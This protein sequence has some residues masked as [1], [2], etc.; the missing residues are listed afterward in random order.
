M[1]NFIVKIAST[2]YR[3]HYIKSFKK[4]CLTKQQCLFQI[5]LEEF[6]QSYV[7]VNSFEIEVVSITS[8]CNKNNL[9]SRKQS[10]EKQH[11]H[12]GQHSGW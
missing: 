7:E 8:F 9:N 3:L 11:A 4:F 12:E 2:L 5:R 6:I 10:L 1:S